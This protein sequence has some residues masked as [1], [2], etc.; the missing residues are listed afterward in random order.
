[1][2]LNGR[3]W[4]KSEKTE[5]MIDFIRAIRQLEKLS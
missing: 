4:V 2:G 5:E 1:V 3:I